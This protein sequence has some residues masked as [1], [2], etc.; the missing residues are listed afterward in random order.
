MAKHAVV[1]KAENR[2]VAGTGPA[3]ATRRQGKTPAIIYGGD[4]G[5]AP[6]NITIDT[7]ELTKEYHKGHFLSKLVDIQ[8]GKESEHVIPRAIQVHP[9]TDEVLHA[10]FLRVTDKTKIAVM[11]KVNFLNEDTCPGLKRGG[12]LNIV[13]R[14]VELLCSAK[15][16]PDHLDVDLG[17]LEIG[18]SA[19]ISSV[20]L[21]KGAT[22][23]ITDRDFT[24]ATLV[25]RMAEEVE[26][27]PAEEE[28]GEEGAETA[29]GEEGTEGE[30]NAEEGKEESGE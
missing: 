8:V 16:I 10:D 5:K 13:R 27:A 17:G 19:H 21:P 25:G 9:V 1:I 2:E 3:R 29:E 7:N 22:P 6:A 12:V 15:N 18:E 23:T 24:I 28:E 30:A 4:Q 26:E 20:T 14:D 11:V